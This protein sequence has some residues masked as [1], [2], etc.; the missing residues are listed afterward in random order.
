MECH[1]GTS[2]ANPALQFKAEPVSVEAKGWNGAA[3]ESAVDLAG[4]RVL[5]MID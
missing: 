5:K 3:L 4:I 2:A 1:I